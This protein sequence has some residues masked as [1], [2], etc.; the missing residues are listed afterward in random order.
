MS[1]GGMDF[2]PQ[3]MYIILVL[4]ISHAVFIININLPTSKTTRTVDE[5]QT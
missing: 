5:L 3:G 2:N 1:Y 4:H